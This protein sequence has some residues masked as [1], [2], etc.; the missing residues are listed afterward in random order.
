MSLADN[1]VIPLSLWVSYA[2]LLIQVHYL[3]GIIFSVPVCEKWS[4]CVWQKLQYP[5]AIPFAPLQLGGAI[6]TNRMKRVWK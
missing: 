3:R 5:L 4:L 6:A 1:P 2:L